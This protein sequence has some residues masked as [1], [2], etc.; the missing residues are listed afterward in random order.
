MPNTAWL[1]LFGLGAIIVLGTWFGFRQFAA[2]SPQFPPVSDFLV[3]GY[4]IQVA[5]HPSPATALKPTTFTV[6]LRD[7]D[8]RPVS[9][10]TGTATISMP[11]ML[12][13]ESP[14]TLTETE[15]GRYVGEGIPL[16]AG[17]S[18]ADVSMTAGDQSLRVRFPFAAVR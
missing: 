4:R 12:C 18:V 3:D 5:L 6:T 17:S 9:G 1:R 8:G 7:A 13:G 11:Q 15:T 14:F 2:T 10:A 16:M